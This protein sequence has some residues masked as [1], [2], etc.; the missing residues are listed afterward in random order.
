MKLVKYRVKKLD[1][2]DGRITHKLEYESASKLSKNSGGYNCGVL[3]R[4]SWKEC[5]KKKKEYENGI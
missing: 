5:H 1:T 3:Y 4:G 2:P